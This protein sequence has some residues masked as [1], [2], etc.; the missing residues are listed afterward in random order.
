MILPVKITHLI[1]QPYV[2]P[3]KGGVKQEERA[4]RDV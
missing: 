3:E 1:K 2:K 4:G